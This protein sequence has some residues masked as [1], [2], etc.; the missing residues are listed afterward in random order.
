MKP[1]SIGGVPAI[2]QEKEN[3]KKGSVNQYQLT[4]LSLVELGI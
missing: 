3:K 1:E 2:L 4:F